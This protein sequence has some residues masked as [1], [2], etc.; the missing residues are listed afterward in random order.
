MTAD[1]LLSAPIL[2]TLVRF[3]L[4]NVGAM[5]GR[6]WSHLSHCRAVRELGDRS[7]IGE[8]TAN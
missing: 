4:P 2:P 5:G 6:L 3:A 1:P 7:M 8:I